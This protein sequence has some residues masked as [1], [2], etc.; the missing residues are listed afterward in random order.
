MRNIT[1]LSRTSKWTYILCISET[2]QKKDVN[3]DLNITIDGYRQP[4]SVGSK[5]S[6]GGVAIYSKTDINVV[7]RNDLNIIDNS[8]EAVWIEVKNEKRKNIVVAAS[9]DTLTVKWTIL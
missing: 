2:S 5:T 3:F 4:T 8:F 1:I 6:K 7:D 9:I